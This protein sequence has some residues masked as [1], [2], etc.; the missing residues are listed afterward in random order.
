MNNVNLSPSAAAWFANQDTCPNQQLRQSSPLPIICVTEAWVT[1]PYC[2]C[3]WSCLKSSGLSVLTMTF[4][5]CSLLLTFLATPRSPSTWSCLFCLLAW[6][7]RSGHKVPTF[8]MEPMPSLCPWS[9]GDE[10]WAVHDK[11][12]C[13][14][15][16]TTLS[17][18]RILE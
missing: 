9:V 3:S 18:P 14:F 15:W 1:K 11:L 2:V 5:S 6:P 8:R 7:G 16:S 4:S 12:P 17:V 13:R 10:G